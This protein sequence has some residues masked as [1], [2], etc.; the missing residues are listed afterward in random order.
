MGADYSFG[1][2]NNLLLKGFV[3]LRNGG[4]LFTLSAIIAIFPGIMYPIYFMQEPELM[5]I[6]LWFFELVNFIIISAA[7]VFFISSFKIIKNNV[8]EK[9]DRLFNLTRILLLIFSITFTLFTIIVLIFHWVNEMPYLSLGKNMIA[10]FLLTTFLI[11]FSFSLKDLERIGYGTRLLYVPLIFLT[12]PSI[13]G[14]I[15]ACFTF[16]EPFGA[17][18]DAVDFSIVFV[19]LYMVVFLFFTFLELSLVLRRMTRMIDVQY[20]LKTPESESITKSPV[21]TKK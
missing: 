5:N 12:V 3:R 8:N 2:D 21:P 7:T 1:M 10:Y 14:G 15:L 17:S 9:K 20:I 6:A 16:I 4:I 11:A 18:F 19:N 13:V